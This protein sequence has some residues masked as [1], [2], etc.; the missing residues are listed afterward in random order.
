MELGLRQSNY[1]Q[2]LD[3]ISKSFCVILVDVST[4]AV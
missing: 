1:A 3:T 2:M 4:W